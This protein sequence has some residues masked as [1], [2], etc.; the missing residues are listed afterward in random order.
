VSAEV[1]AAEVQYT[2]A[3]LRILLLPLF[4]QCRQLNRASKLDAA[5]THVG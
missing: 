2:Q 4:G 1:L 3:A 5:V